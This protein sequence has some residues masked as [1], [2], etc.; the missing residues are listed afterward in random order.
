M[1][2]PGLEYAILNADDPSVER[3]REQLGP[4]VRRVEYGLARGD[5]RASGL[6][7]SPD[8]SRYRLETPAGSVL[9]ETRL[10]GRFNVYN[11]LAVAATLH[12]SGWALADIG[13][14][15]AVAEPVP[16]RM[17]A[18][19]LPGQPVVVVDYAHTPDALEQTLR[20]LRD[21]GVTGRLLCVFGCGGDRDRGK[22]PAMG[23]VAEEL[24][25]RVIVTDDNPRTEDGDRIVSE[26]LAG[27][28]DPSRAIV[29]RNRAAA[30]A[31][32]VALAA[33]GD[34][35]LVAGKGHED[36]QEVGRDR[37]PFDDREVARRTLEAAP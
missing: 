34:I 17:E 33:S 1:S 36:Y 30:I 25:D 29:E 28:D 4:G 14:A 9:V 37:L 16:G 15:L 12:A 2:W 19:S 26:I 20:A 24:A 21:H 13:T 22:R 35:V 7:F 5:V 11:A 3:F 6:A 32:A 31:A 27:L 23:R 10:L 8:G 18:L